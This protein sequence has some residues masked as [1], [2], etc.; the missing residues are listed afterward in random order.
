MM[1]IGHVWSSVSQVARPSPISIETPKYSST[2]RPG[3]EIVNTVKETLNTSTPLCHHFKDQVYY[4]FIF[5]S[6]QIEKGRVIKQ[7]NL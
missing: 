3:K 5:L 7:T 2:R 4:D 1:V 6:L